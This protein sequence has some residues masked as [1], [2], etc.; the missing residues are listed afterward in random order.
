MRSTS[1]L[2]AAALCLVSACSDNI[3]V[4]PTA[5]A[6]SAFSARASLVETS[7]EVAS[8]GAGLSE[9]NEQ[10]AAAGM[11]FRIAKAELLYRGFNA[12]ASTIILANDRARGI[13]AEWVKNDPRRGGRAGVTYTIGS[14]TG[15]K[16]F[17]LL[18]VT[19]AG[20][21]L[22]IPTSTQLE[23]QI[24]EAMDAWRGQS[25]SSAPITRVA[26][27]PNPDFLDEAYR[28]IP[29]I[30]YQPT[31]DIVQ[32]LWHPRQFFRNVA[33][34]AGMPAQFG[35]FIIGA[36][37]TSVFIDPVASQEA[38]EPVFTDIDGNG[39]QDIAAAEIYY[40]GWL[41]FTTGAGYIWDNQAR[42][43]FTDYF[44]ILAHE[45]GHS[46]GLGHFGKIFATK[47]DNE[48]DNGVLF[49]DELKYA[50]RALM[51]AAYITGRSEIA[52]T[53]NSSFCQIWASKGRKLSLD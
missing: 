52:G 16:P 30:T 19:P 34:A 48:D 4:E 36:T 38:G 39:K 7:D 5:A 46:L 33:V 6:L 24:E 49:H 15:G 35:D 47:K 20:I 21:Q 9:M 51:N 41:D 18:A 3:P 12:Q 10:L 26:P 43:G 53:D 11:N 31:A 29:P 27:G 17:G 2:S 44:S 37:F 25:C 28:G 32:G 14:N 1:V 8:V 22:F 45:T 13:G 50:P 23:G 40:A 42:L